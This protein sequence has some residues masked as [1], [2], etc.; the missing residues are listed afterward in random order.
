MDK[1]IRVIFLD[2]DGV[3]NSFAEDRRKTIKENGMTN[4]GYVTFAEMWCPEEVPSKNLM[5]IANSFPNTEVVISSVWRFQCDSCHI[6]ECLLFAAGGRT[7]P[8]SVHF[9][10]CTPRSVGDKPRGYDI[11]QWL[12]KH[13]ENVESF[14]I[15]DDDYDLEPYMS[16]AVIVDGEV[17]LTE[18]DVDKAIDILEREWK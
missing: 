18:A 8:I 17:G 3:L 7:A 9:N 4:R 5:K 6:W 10:A 2:I 13:G 1:P 16:R 12:D 15:L 11:Q 14:V